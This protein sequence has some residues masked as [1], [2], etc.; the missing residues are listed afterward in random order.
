M[1]RKIP[2][3]DL[4]VPYNSPAFGYMSGLFCFEIVQ[5]RS[6]LAVWT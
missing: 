2:R 6:G 5:Q 4:I 1:K 3:P